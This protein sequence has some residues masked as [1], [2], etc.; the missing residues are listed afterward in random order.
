MTPSLGRIV[1][2]HTAEKYNGCD[3]H[4]AIINRVWGDNDPAAARG[5]YSCVNLTVFPD[6]ASPFSMTSVQL[7]ETEEEARDSGSRHIAWWP[8]RA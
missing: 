3:T 1:L 7:F 8:A 6:C 2:V 4:P 5:A